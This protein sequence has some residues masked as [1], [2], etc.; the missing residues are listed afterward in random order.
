MSK[1][2]V[3][4]VVSTRAVS[5]PPS[6]YRTAGASSV[7]LLGS[8]GQNTS[9]YDPTPGIVPNGYVGGFHS[10]RDMDCCVPESFWKNQK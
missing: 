10:G 2:F 7:V 5:G 1:S 4:M 8:D 9:E 3:G 6:N